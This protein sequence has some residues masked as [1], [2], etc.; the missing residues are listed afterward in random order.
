VGP[1]RDFKLN[2]SGKVFGFLW[3]PVSHGVLRGLPGMCALLS[4]VKLAEALPSDEQNAAKLFPDSQELRQL[5]KVS[6]QE[7]RGPGEA[8]SLSQD[9]L[10]G[11]IR[12]LQEKRLYQ[13]AEEGVQIAGGHFQAC[14]FLPAE[15]PQ[16]EYRV[17]VYALE[18]GKARL[19]ANEFFTARTEGLAAW[20]ARQ[21][22]DN[23]T[24][25]AIIAVL[26]ALAAGALVGVI[27]QLGTKR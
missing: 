27:F 10:R 19:L 25:Y 9:F 22:R 21:A 14:L 15:A 16:G 1:E 26:I 7:E 20:L 12:I 24:V 17:S 8:E 4:S 23:P 11:L 2:K 18:G 3:V 13:H 6:F 5:G